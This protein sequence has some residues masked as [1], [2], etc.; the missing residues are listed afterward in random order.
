MLSDTLKFQDT[1]S[2]IEIL[3]KKGKKIKLLYSPQDQSITLIPKFSLR[4]INTENLN[5]SDIKFKDDPFLM[6]MKNYFSF[7]DIEIRTQT[8]LDIINYASNHSI[9]KNI[10]LDMNNYKNDLSILER[11]HIVDDLFD[12]DS[13]DKTCHMP[14]TESN[15]MSVDISEDEL[16]E[17]QIFPIAKNFY[18]RDEDTYSVVEI[19]DPIVLKKYSN[20]IS[21]FN[22]LHKICK[23][24]RIK[25]SES[26]MMV[27]DTINNFNKTKCI[28]SIGIGDVQLEGDSVTNSKE[29]ARASASQELLKKMFP[30]MKWK[31][32]VEAFIDN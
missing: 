28:L 10:A 13:E 9:E 18:S 17:D 29:T 23:K 1:Y 31:D 3:D 4:N 12:S 27:N 8:A 22:L 26:F 21:P 15:N 20:R 25:L 30:Q 19:N 2:V 6:S 7:F 11:T 14:F 16:E 5:K 32:L 24:N